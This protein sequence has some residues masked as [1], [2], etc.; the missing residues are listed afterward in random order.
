MARMSI[1]DWIYLN[2]VSSAAAIHIG[3]NIRTTLVSQA[4]AVQREVPYYSG[5]EGNLEPFPFF[6]RPIPLPQPG[7]PVTMCVNNWGSCIRVGGIRILGISSS[8]ALH[9]GSNRCIEGVSRI[10]HFRQFVSPDPEKAP[11]LTMVEFGKSPNS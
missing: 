7:E 8:A 4:L 5:K 6:R 2:D 9:V 11:K 1:V 10:K 3:D